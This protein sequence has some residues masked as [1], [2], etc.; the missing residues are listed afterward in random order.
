MLALSNILNSHDVSRVES[1]KDTTTAQ[2]LSVYIR[3]VRNRCGVSEKDSPEV[4]QKKSPCL[5]IILEHLV[6]LG[7]ERYRVRY[8]Q[9]TTG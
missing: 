9:L 3:I 7:L 8:Y 2:R 5:G 6:A 4:A 1:E